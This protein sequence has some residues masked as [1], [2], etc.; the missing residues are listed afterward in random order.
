MAAIFGL[1]D[2]LAIPRGTR[3]KRIGAIHGIGNVIVLLLFTASW[4][5]R[6]SDPAYPGKAALILGFA[7]ILLALGTGWLGGELVYRLGIGIDE[8]S[9]VNAPNSLKSEPPHEAGEGLRTT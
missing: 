9:N 4:V 3:A 6:F 5:L 7:G 1:T 8:G 2:Y